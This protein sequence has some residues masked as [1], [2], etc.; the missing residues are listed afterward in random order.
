MLQFNI[1]RMHGHWQKIA[2]GATVLP[3]T[4]TS[5]V[6]VVVYVINFFVTTP[7]PFFEDTVRSTVQV[8]VVLYF[9]ST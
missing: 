6:Q 2:A 9:L 3:T 4:G 5:T 7:V 8:Q 1:E